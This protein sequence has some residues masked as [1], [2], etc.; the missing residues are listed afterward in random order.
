MCVVYYRKS[1]LVVFFF[2][3]WVQFL[4]LHCLLINEMFRFSKEL[5]TQS[6]NNLED[7]YPGNDVHEIR[8]HCPAYGH[9]LRPSI[10][11]IRPGEVTP[12]LLDTYV[13]AG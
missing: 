5:H 3:L 6:G 9:S 1:R 12:L 8:F 2:A 10:C 11:E 7:F 4:F 13:L